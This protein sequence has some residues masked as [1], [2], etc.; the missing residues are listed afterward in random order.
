MSKKP[1]H[2]HPG[3]PSSSSGGYRHE[4]N[5]RFS[6]KQ[7]I[8]EEEYV[9]KDRSKTR[10]RQA[11]RQDSHQQSW[12]DSDFQSLKNSSNRGGR[13]GDSLSK[14]GH[15]Q[16]QSKQKPPGQNRQADSTFDSNNS[17]HPSQYRTNKSDF[18]Y[19]QDADHFRKKDLKQ[20]ATVLHDE[21]E[22]RSG[23]KHK[24][25]P[26]STTYEHLNARDLSEK[27]GWG[28][29][30]SA[31]EMREF[32]KNP[33][34]WNSRNSRMQNINKPSH[35]YS[36]EPETNLGLISGSFECKSLYKFLSAY[37]GDRRLDR[38]DPD[39]GKQF[40]TQKGTRCSSKNSTNWMTNTW[41]R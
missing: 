4:E 13:G 6:Q 41:T 26:K 22:D 30:K 2:P 39:L 5:S 34:V 8:N 16:F 21:S 37:Q 38:E 7:S 15:H 10:G 17:R 18:R 28:E 24:H 40:F 35:Q 23:V 32:K 9:R 20:S 31:N 36:F 11:P 27:A 12:A 29:E 3:K 19:T 25:H 33:V 14:S 1:N